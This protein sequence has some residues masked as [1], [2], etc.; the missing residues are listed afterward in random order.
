MTELTEDVIVKKLKKIELEIFKEFVCVCEKLNIE[1]YALGGTC[2]GAVRHQ[3]FIPWDDDIDVG[4]KREDY[5]LFIREG[6]KL[7][8]KNLFIQTINTDCEYKHN[9]A[10]IRKSD[11]TFIET[12]VKNDHIN[13]GVYMDVFPLDFCTDKKIP[14][15][16]LWFKL[17]LVNGYINK[18]FIDVSEKI[19]WKGAILKFIYPILFKSVNDALKKRERIYKSVKESSLIANFG[20]AWG[21]KE[22]VP[23]KIFEESIELPFEDIKMKVPKLYKDYLK[24]LYGDYMKLPP[25]EQRVTHHYTEVLDL[26]KPYTYYRKE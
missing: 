23:A 21:E 17:N 16:V 1:Y 15:K 6:Q 18:S 14:Y 26:D 3:G 7:L 24:C 4:L 11:T 10:K 22:V 2:L 9:F 20:G 13:H 25:L 8:N 12:S 5:E 19:T